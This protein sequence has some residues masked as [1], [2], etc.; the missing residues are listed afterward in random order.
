LWYKLP[1]NKNIRKT[2]F[3]VV[4][5]YL[6]ATIILV[7]TLSFLYIQNQKNNIF[8][9]NKQQ[10]D[11]R[12][13]NIIEKLEILHDNIIN[14][15]AI[16][17]RYDDIKSAIYDKDK[18]LI[19]ST[20]KQKIKLQSKPYFFQDDFVYFIYKVELHYLG[21]NFLVIQKQRAYEL[22]SKF[23]KIAFVVFLII[24]FLIFT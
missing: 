12:A 22:K 18:N 19:F 13:K 11:I 14:E 7:L 5:V 3:N 10:L 6:L 24:I 20:F 8:E 2:I 21:A 9:L 1:K 16:Y 4:S 17:P 15:I 23:K